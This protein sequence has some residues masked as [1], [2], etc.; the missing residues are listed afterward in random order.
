M[1]SEHK[2]T[3]KKKKYC[4]VTILKMTKVDNYLQ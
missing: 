2:S 3:D 4:P 1:S